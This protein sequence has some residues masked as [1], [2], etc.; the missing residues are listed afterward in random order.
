LRRRCFLE[1]VSAG[2][3]AHCAKNPL[4]VFVDGQHHRRDPRVTL[5]QDSHAVDAV[6]SRKPDIDQGHTR[7]VGSN[8]VER[9]FHGTI[10]MPALETVS[11][12]DEKRQTFPGFLLVFDNAGSDDGHDA[13]V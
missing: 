12:V 7:R 5:A 9:R 4:V 2:A 3:G 8:S 10:D 11:V 6:E 13:S 1:Q